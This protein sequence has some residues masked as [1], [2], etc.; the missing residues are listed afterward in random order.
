M[1]LGIAFRILVLEHAQSRAPIASDGHRCAQR[2]KSCTRAKRRNA[3]AA[4]RLADKNG[5]RFMLAF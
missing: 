4:S 1:A 2:A 3:P 5:G